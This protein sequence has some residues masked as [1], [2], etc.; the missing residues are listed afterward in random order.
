MVTKIIQREEKKEKMISQI[1]ITPEMVR[2][3]AKS[4]E[5]GIF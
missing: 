5:G 4:K 1:P 2:D 3:F